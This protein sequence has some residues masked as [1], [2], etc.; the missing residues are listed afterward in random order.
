MKSE[1]KIPLVCTICTFNN[2]SLCCHKSCAWN[3][4]D[5]FDAG[6][7]LSEEI[8]DKDDRDDS[9][10]DKIR[11]P[12]VEKLKKYKIN[13][14]VEIPIA[15][16]ILYFKNKIVYVGQT[17]HIKS[18]IST[19]DK[20]RISIDG[21]TKKDKYFDS[22]SFFIVN[23]SIESNAIEYYLINKYKPPFNGNNGCEWKAFDKNVFTDEILEKYDIKRCDDRRFLDKKTNHIYGYNT[24]SSNKI[25]IDIIAKEYDECPII[26][27]EEEEYEE[28]F[29]GLNLLDAIHKK[30][31]W[32]YKH[33][34]LERMKDLIQLIS[35]C[36]NCYDI[37]DLK[38]LKYGNGL[39]SKCTYEKYKKEIIE[40]RYE[41]EEVIKYQKNLSN[42]VP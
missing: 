33:D 41:D 35:L 34:S 17:T 21:M 2:H 9:R 29:I 32:W 26:K 27:T 7:S 20:S 37:I 40:M 22:F 10:E 14:K 42:M 16:Y 3:D 6:Y 8:Y 38:G 36:E 18:R 4:D 23:N 30:G 1:D 39:C 5:D 15:I 11:I 31:G 12:N 28:G 24:K 13:E 19:H 25:L